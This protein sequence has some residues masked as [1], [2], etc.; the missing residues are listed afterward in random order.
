MEL[1]RLRDKEDIEGFCCQ[2]AKHPHYAP[3]PTLR[4]KKRE[5]AC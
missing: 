5:I 1:I 3:L 2:L 4:L